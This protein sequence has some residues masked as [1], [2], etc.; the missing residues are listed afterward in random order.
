MISNF[1]F[2]TKM[3]INFPNSTDGNEQCKSNLDTYLTWEWSLLG[4]HSDTAIKEERDR[5]FQ[6]AQLL[7]IIGISFDQ[8]PAC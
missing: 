7:K 5:K 2:T 1:L 4:W 3:S 6:R 8:Q